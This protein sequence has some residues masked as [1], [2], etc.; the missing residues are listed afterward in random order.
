MGSP[1]LRFA[2]WEVPRSPGAREVVGS[3][4]TDPTI[5]VGSIE[6][7]LSLSYSA[8][9]ACA[10]RE[11]CFCKRDCQSAWLAI[12][13]NDDLSARQCEVKFSIPTI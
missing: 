3:N 1:G 8:S 4:P 2:A 12:E 9:A 13:G 7:Y 10:L 11:S 6:A 5:S